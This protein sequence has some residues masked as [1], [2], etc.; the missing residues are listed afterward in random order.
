MNEFLSSDPRHLIT[1]VFL[2]LSLDG[3][4]DWWLT[5]PELCRLLSKWDPSCWAPA[6][7]PLAQ[8]YSLPLQLPILS[9]VISI[10]W[11]HESWEPC[12]PG[13]SLTSCAVSGQQSHKWQQNTSV[14]EP[15]LSSYA[16]PLL[17]I[18][19]VCKAGV[20]IFLALFISP[21][22]ESHLECNILILHVLHLVWETLGLMLGSAL[23]WGLGP[24]GPFIHL[25][26]SYHVYYYT[27]WDAKTDQTRTMPEKAYNPESE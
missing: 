12:L 17:R 15:S 5:V 23:P 9:W 13:D 8:N 6:P 20:C 7:H 16:S 24:G 2:Y 4:S 18:N 19:R 14:Y 26:N 22:W 10:H 1:W 25:F 21:E 27:A 3:E 11:N